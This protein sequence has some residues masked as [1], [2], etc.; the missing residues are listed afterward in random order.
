MSTTALND[1][2]K[3][4]AAALASGMSPVDTRDKFALTSSTFETW[5]QNDAFVAE[6]QRLQTEG[7]TQEAKAS[8]DASGDALDTELNRMSQA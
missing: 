6:V 4:V 5:R 3:Q 7:S 8:D 2:Q 1:L